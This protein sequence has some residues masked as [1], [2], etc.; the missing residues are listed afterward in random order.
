M[1]KQQLDRVYKKEMEHFTQEFKDFIESMRSNEVIFEHP[2]YFVMFCESAF[3][4]MK[5]GVVPETCIDGKG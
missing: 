1:D 3:N 4:E 2:Y 5:Y